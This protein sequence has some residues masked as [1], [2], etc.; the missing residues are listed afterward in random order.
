MDAVVLHWDHV[1]AP[2]RACL[3]KRAQHC[4][5]SAACITTALARGKQRNHS[6]SVGIIAAGI[7]PEAKQRFIRL[8][9]SRYMFNC[10]VCVCIYHIRA[11]Q[12]WRIKSGLQQ[13]PVS[14]F[15]GVWNWSKSK[16]QM[17]S[18]KFEA[19]A[20]HLTAKCTAFIWAFGLQRAN[21]PNWGFCPPT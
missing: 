13:E 10:R 15:V 18:N 9:K 3:N 4:Q 20:K 6:F 11:A 17:T 8:A 21:Q 16:S 14:C 2:L 19:W 12:W 7:W 1:T 5:T